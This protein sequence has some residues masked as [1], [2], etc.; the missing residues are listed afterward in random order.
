MAHKEE[1]LKSV[2]ARLGLLV[3]TLK[4]KQEA[5]RKQHGHYWQ[6]LRTHDKAPKDGEK[7]AGNK[8]RKPTDQS[9]SWEDM[10][11]SISDEEA[12]FAVD[13]YDGAQGKGY[14]ITAEFELD[15]KLYVRVLNF[16]PETYRDMP[17]KE[18]RKGPLN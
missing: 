14:T 17:W 2:D 1:I 9:E 11:V 13:V 4:T 10:G 3:D 8:K 5:Y 16:G 15:G 6:G 7:K 18:F 12:S